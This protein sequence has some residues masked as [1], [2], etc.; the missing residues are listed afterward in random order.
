MD[1]LS[2]KIVLAIAILA[3]GW[4]GGVIPLGRRSGAGGGRFMSWGNAFAAGIFLGIGLIHMLGEAQ[5]TWAELG[6]EYPMAFVLATAAFAAILLFEHVLLPE[7]AHA[8]VH[9][10]GH[11]CVAEHEMEGTDGGSYSYV[12]VVALSLHSVLAGIALGA[13]D[14]LANV[15]IIFI[16]I[17]AHKSTAGF[18]LGVSLARDEVG[19]RRA[20]GLVALFSAMTPIGILLGMTVSGLLQSAGE[21]YFDAT[22]L[23]L[24]AGTFIYIASLDII[25]D[26]FLRPGSR[27]MKWL[28]AT[29][30]LILMAVLAIWI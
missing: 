18:A 16:A 23:A 15:L 4:V 30:G 28:F 9:H 29:L 11:D 8:M 14:T 26:E 7:R 22:V 12:L 19:E 20:F 2:T 1:L 5:R 10:H 24:A 27:F 13:Q 3:A 17:V 6:W 25:Q 21:R